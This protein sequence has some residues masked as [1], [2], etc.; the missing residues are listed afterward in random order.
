MKSRNKLFLENAA[1]VGGT[2]WLMRK[3]LQGSVFPLSSVV[4]YKHFLKPAAR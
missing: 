4:G 3:R 1:L 2:A